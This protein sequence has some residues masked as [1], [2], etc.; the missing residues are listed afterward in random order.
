M[1]T[2]S[3]A[4]TAVLVLTAAVYLPALSFGFVCDD[5]QQI[6]DSQPR[7]VWSALPSFFTTD[8]WHYTDFIDS[9]YYRPGFLLWLFLNSQL[10]GL[11][12][13]LWHA[14]AIALHLAATLLFYFLARR[15][16]DHPLIAGAAALLFGVH[17]AH[18]E[19]VA[20]L[21]GVTESLLAVF[22]LGALL[23]YLSGRRT[24][25]LL[26]FAAAIFTKETAIVLPLL[27]AACDWF[28][29][30]AAAASSRQ[31]LRAALRTLAACACI[32]L[33]YLPLR[34]HALGSLAPL[35]RAWT[36]RMLLGTLPSA[37]LFY[38]RQLL[39]PIQ[40]S[41]F[42]PIAPI[43][44]FGWSQ[45]IL[46]VL[47]IALFLLLLYGLAR[48]SRAFAFAALLLVIPLLPVF[49]FRAFA[50]DDFQHDRYLYLPSAGLCLVIALAAARF[51]RSPAVRIAALAA[52]CAA[53]AY[54]NL[55][56]SG[57]WAD[58]LSLYTHA[59]QVAPESDIAAEYLG[60]ELLAQQRFADAL[61]LFQKVLFHDGRMSIYENLAMC[62]LGLD[63]YSRASAFLS[64]TMTLFPRAHEP[65]FFMAQLYQRQGQLSEAEA[66]ARQALRLRPE[67]SPVLAKYHGRLASILADENQY[68]AAL[69]EY[70]QELKENP[71]A[72]EAR[73]AIEQLRARGVTP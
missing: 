4:P 25:A 27:L 47:V 23:A 68:P 36:P 10:F 58:N 67:A 50:F 21:S 45:T 22:F 49:N 31:R 5:S 51:L 44:T 29:P 70:Q 59:S 14:A 56:F 60:G 71:F 53:F 13:V 7:Y 46:P 52:L 38:L 62:Y 42:Y 55:Q 8:V 19:A 18:I 20:W 48:L 72:Q 28:F 3:L 35:V 11:N 40:Y 37:G 65:H 57:Y 32:V 26:L 54:A 64:Q 33:L 39:L 61:P 73:D 30:P 24:A 1:N 69:A 66:E 2:R 15:L 34:L 17:P 63:D 9:N 6:V 43:A 41:L 12:T 16:V